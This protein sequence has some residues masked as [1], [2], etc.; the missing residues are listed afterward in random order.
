MKVL[1]TGGTG[2]LGRSVG[3]ALV[4]RGHEI[5]VLVRP[6]RRPADLPAQW[7]GVEGDVTDP[8]SLRRALEALRPASALAIVHLAALVKMWVRDRAEFDR[9][10]VG[11]LLNV[12]EAARGAGVARIVYGSSFMALGPSNGR[13]LNE[14][15]VHP[16]DR[17]H[18]DYERTKYLADVE[19]RRLMGEGAP[20][21]AVYPGVVYG[22]GPLTAGGIATRQVREFLLGRLP[23]ILG[24]GDQ[25]ICYAYVEDV[26]N[27]FVLAL[28]RGTLGRRYILGGENATMNDLLRRL[29]RLSGRPAPT[30]HIPYALAACVGR[31]QWWRAALT[32]REPDL[33]HEVVNVYRRAWAYDSSR[34]CAELGYRIT[35]LDTGLERT[36]AWIREGGLAG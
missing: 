3:Q 14:D 13:P 15:D 17:F 24:P 22:P 5:A 10:N 35:P 18:N 26:A 28:E 32:G 33:T 19:A 4:A 2:F 29:A 25:P 8:A 9:V 16:G 36:I 34:S 30:R 31:L 27:G 11:G 12:V 23:G 7:P 21:I 6:G 1:L 20:L